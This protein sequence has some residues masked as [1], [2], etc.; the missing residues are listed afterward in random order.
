MNLDEATTTEPIPFDDYDYY[1]YTD[2]DYD[3]SLPPFKMAPESSYLSPYRYK[4][5]MNIL[6]YS[7]DYDEDSYSDEGEVEPEKP[8]YG[9]LDVISLNHLNRSKLDL[10]SQI[11]I[12]SL[13]MVGLFVLFRYFR[14]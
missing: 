11:Y 14:K 5:T 4:K 8:E 2:L 10:M 12:G 3:D 9:S 6:S 7:E 1:E 13:T